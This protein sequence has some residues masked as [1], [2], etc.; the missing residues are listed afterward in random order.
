[1]YCLGALTHEPYT[2]E[3][4]EILYNAKSIKCFTLISWLATL[5]EEEREGHYV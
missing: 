1:M 4:K 3:N 2:I 5:S